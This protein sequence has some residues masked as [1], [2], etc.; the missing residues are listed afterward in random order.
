MATAVSSDS[1]ERDFFR[2]EVAKMSG[3]TPGEQ[4]RSTS[5]I[6]LNTNE[7]PYPPTPAV[8]AAA[9][10]AA[11]Q[12]ARYPDPIAADV[13]QAAAE[14]HGAEADWII[15]GN[16]SDD[17]LTIVVRACVRQG[18]ALATFAPTYSLYPVLA[19]IQGARCIEIPLGPEFALPPA[20]AT[21]AGDASLLIITNPNAPTGNAFPAADVTAWC[22]A[23]P[24]L[25]LIDEAYVDFAANDCSQLARD[26]PN[27]VVS[28][29][30]SKGYSLAG[31]RLGYAFARP[32]LISQL[33]KV[34][35]SYNVNATTQAVAAAALRDQAHMRANVNRV[36][37]TRGRVATALAAAGFDVLPSQTNF[38]FVRPPVPTPAYLSALRERD[39]IVRHF[40]GPRV[41]EFVRVTIGTDAEMD[42]FLAATGA[43]LQA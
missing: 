21:A 41:R 28:R 19:D 32:A 13:R 15:A 35:D 27:V 11:G 3:Y 26:L 37:A 12:L 43:I 30:L 9:A 24:G 40:D 17:I 39:I 31:I 7:N 29:T 5:L 4:P 16:G 22:R 18:G 42:Q 33:L 38:L 2:P 34:K 36:I 6:K 10:V 25:V 14:L 20:N 1:S 23:F 8:A